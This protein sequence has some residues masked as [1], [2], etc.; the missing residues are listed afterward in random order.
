MIYP[1]ESPSILHGNTPRKGSTL[2][3]FG[4]NRP[5]KNLS[6]IWA[7]GSF[8][9]AGPEENAVRASTGGMK[10]ILAPRQRNQIIKAFLIHPTDQIVDPLGV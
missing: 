4:H 1:P 6:S 3:L 2:L 8:F 7:A 5:M 10:N 9:G